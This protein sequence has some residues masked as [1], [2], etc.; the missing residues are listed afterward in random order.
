MDD[1]DPSQRCSRCSDRHT[2]HAPGLI[3]IIDGPPVH[4][5]REPAGHDIRALE[6]AG[7]GCCIL[8]AGS[9]GGAAPHNRGRVGK[10][11]PWLQVSW[12]PRRRSVNQRDNSGPD[13]QCQWPQQNADYLTRR[14]RCAAARIALGT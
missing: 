9:P 10:P 4:E 3:A 1:E 14:L 6:R 11:T 7:S 13:E 12:P 8:H 5:R 2:V